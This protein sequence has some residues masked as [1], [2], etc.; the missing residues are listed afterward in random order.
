MQVQIYDI[1]QADR[2][3]NLAM[4]HTCRHRLYSVFVGLIHNCQERTAGTVQGHS[5]Q[6]SLCHPAAWMSV[7]FW[8]LQI[9]RSYALRTP[10]HFERNFYNCTT[11]FLPFSPLL[12]PSIHFP[13]ATPKHCSFLTLTW[14]G[15]STA[16]IQR[17]ILG[18]RCKL[19]QQVRPPNA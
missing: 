13:L 3:C 10:G 7:D 16:H 18:E 12:L 11:P 5:M 19:P 4:S 9:A 6:I 2:H 8:W 17:G 14:G 1:S 15:G